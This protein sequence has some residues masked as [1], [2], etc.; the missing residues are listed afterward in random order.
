MARIVKRNKKKVYYNE[1]DKKKCMVLRELCRSGVI[2]DGEIDERP[3]QEVRAGDLSGYRQCH[4]FAGIGVWAYAVRRVGAEGVDGLW[5]GSCPCQSFSEA[6]KRKGFEDE[7]HLWPS[8]FRLIEKRSP[9]VVFG[10][11]V[12]A[13]IGH[14]WLDLVQSDLEGAG[15]SCGP[16]VFPAAGAGA[17]HV[18]HRLWFVAEGMAHAK[19]MGCKWKS[20]SERKV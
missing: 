2:P 14:G 16:V 19:G 6:G 4:F 11:Q 9:R 1:F 15:Y 3:I 12:E 7:R 5:T 13:A 8:W 17:P 10:E 18:R 20:V